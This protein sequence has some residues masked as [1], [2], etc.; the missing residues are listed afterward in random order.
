MLKQ[1][2]FITFIH[3]TRIQSELTEVISIDQ[4]QLQGVR[5]P[6]ADEFLGIP[7]ADCPER[8][9]PAN[10][11]Q[12]WSGLFYATT[13]APGCY[14][15]CTSFPSACPAN[16][17]ECCFTL[18]LYRPRQTMSGANLPIMVHFH[19][20][21]YT[22]GA[23]GVPLLNASHLVGL[24]TNII[25]VTCNYRL[26]AFGFWFNLDDTN[27]TAPGNVALLDQRK[28][29]YWIQNNAAA[30]GGDP[31]N[32]TMW[33]Q[34]AGASSVGFH[35]QYALLNRSQP[36]LFHRVL[37]QSWPAGI[38]PRAL[39]GSQLYNQNFAELAG[40]VCITNVTECLRNKTADEIVQASKE[41]EY[42]VF[43]Y[44][45]KLLT[46][47]LPWEATLELNSFYLK[48]NNVDFINRYASQITI[49]VHWGTNKDEGTLFIYEAINQSTPIS[50]PTAEFL[51]SALWHPEN[52]LMISTLYNITLFNPTTDYHDTISQILA[53]YAF[54][55]PVRNMSR[56][57][58]LLVIQIYIHTFLI[59]FLRQMEHYM[60]HQTGLQ[61]VIPVYV[62]RVKCHSFLIHLAYQPFNLQTMNKPSL[63]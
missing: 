20:G 18:N 62:I 31:S 46:I 58:V 7:Y 45:D 56:A 57:L 16:V 41:V 13:P 17:S 54:T 8:F 11:A 26:G 15:N 35:L 42:D 52:S 34:S 61:N 1:L 25:I 30:F 14:Q 33:G 19:G 9:A 23:A 63:S 21:S 39:V 43:T 6:D 53:D 22:S 51:I 48:Y 24:S 4:G 29:L 40:C 3:V 37:F 12:P 5:N 38:Q 55:C 28:C 44:P 32:V 49:P 59:T 10:D 36:S 60:V 27:V 47:G 50:Y 2:L